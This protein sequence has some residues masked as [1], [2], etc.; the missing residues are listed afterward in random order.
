MHN[1]YSNKMRKII[2]IILMMIF[3]LSSISFAELAINEDGR[4]NSAKLIYTKT[5][6]INFPQES[7]FFS[8]NIPVNLDIGCEDISLWNIANP[9]YQVKNVSFKLIYDKR[10]DNT[11]FSS[12]I[13]TY[14]ILINDTGCSVG[15]S[16]CD[17]GNTPITDRK[18]EYI[19]RDG[20]SLSV[21]ETT[22]FNNSVITDSPCS[23]L[24]TATSENCRG[25][26]AQ[27]YE[28]TIKSLDIRKSTFD[29]KNYLYSIVSNT[30]DFNYMIWNIVSWIIKIGVIFFVIIGTIYVLFY[31]VFFIKEKLK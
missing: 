21:Q 27:T 23:F 2:P 1:I 13:P 11:L 30:I 12:T 15:S 24:I 8:K 20:E 22:Y 4:S 3:V 28:Q 9:N 7:R 10:T 14:E 19:L 25:C 29:T 31:F 16:S 18:I 6:N 5:M 17:T 26:S